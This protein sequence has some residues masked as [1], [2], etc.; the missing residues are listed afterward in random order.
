MK[1]RMQA[2]RIWALLWL[3]L[4]A[5]QAQTTS[6]QVYGEGK[7]ILLLTEDDSKT[8]I[9]LINELTEDSF[10]VI[11]PEINACKEALLQSDSLNDDR[12]AMELMTIATRLSREPIAVVGCGNHTA[13][14][15]RIAQLYPAQVDRIVALGETTYALLPCPIRQVSEGKQA[16]KAIEPFL[17]ADLKAL[18]K[19]GKSQDVKKKRI[20]VDLSHSQCIDTYKGYETYPYLLP[21]YE[22]MMQELDE[23][24]EL[25]IHEKGELSAELLAEADVVLMLSPLNKGL[26]KNLT[27]AERKNLVH[28]VGAGGSLLFFIDDAH[29]VDWQ[30]YG[31]AAVVGPYGIEFGADVPLPGNVGA[32]AFPNRI[33]KAR[34]EIPY[35]GACLMRGG[36]PVS[37]CMEGGYLHGTVVEL[38]NGGKLYVGGDTMV[39]LLLGYADGE[40]LCMDRMATRWWGKDSWNY[41]KELL[42]WAL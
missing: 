40:R 9:E 37:V 1:K 39:G 23:P 18:L 13:T 30:A 31:A 6:Y 15:C 41:M 17:Q 8:G 29:R 5:L 4:S 27:E 22:R 35:S 7:T 11:V 10:Q 42:N 21:A 14:A 33:F 26:Q 36:E 32:I 24:A 34:Y 16:W 12:L 20:L 38:S 25:V 2:L 19:E 28:Y 3:T